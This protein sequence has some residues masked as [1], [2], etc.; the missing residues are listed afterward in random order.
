MSRD[1]GK[2][3]AM[4]APGNGAP[5][6]DRATSKSSR[7]CPCRLYPRFRPRPSPPLGYQI[8]LVP[9]DFGSAREPFAKMMGQITCSRSGQIDVL[10]T[11][12]NDS[13]SQNLM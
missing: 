8:D 3:T 7:Q 6:H 10:P 5:S 9:K 1:L 11:H 13:V 12:L 2:E 4:G